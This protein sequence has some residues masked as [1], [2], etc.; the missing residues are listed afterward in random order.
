MENIKITSGKFRGRNIKSPKSKLTHP[1][2]SREK[3]ALFNMISASLPDAVVLDAFAGSGALG[4]EAI[5]RGAESVVFVEK[6]GSIAKIIR[7]NIDSLGL[8]DYAKVITGDIKD[9]NPTMKFDI[10]IADPP[11]D[12][13]DL[14]NVLCLEK[15]LKND[16]GL[17]LSHPDRIV[18]INNLKLEKT[19]KYS[20]AYISIYK[21][22]HNL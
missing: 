12:N 2:G 16:G 7:E 20:S 17:V 10:I 5:S 14:T 13:F 4:I 15:F 11:Y 6:A 1:M 8:G 3:I 21:K 18:E 19:H 9:F 22:L